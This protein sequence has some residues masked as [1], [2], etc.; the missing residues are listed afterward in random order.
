MRCARFDLGE[1]RKFIKLMGEIVAQGQLRRRDVV[2][3][4]LSGTSDSRRVRVEMRVNDHS[5]L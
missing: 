2:C 3:G 1:L 4:S 5:A